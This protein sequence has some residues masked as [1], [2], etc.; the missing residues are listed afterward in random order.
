MSERL[1]REYIG[2]VTK[3]DKHL[4]AEAKKFNAGDV[5]EGIMAAA[6]ATKLMKRPT[7]MKE[8]Y[9]A[10]TVDDVQK[11]LKMIRKNVSKGPGVKSVSRSW[12][13]PGIPGGPS[14]DQIDNITL[15]IALAPSHMAA[16]LDP[17]SWDDKLE[18]Y[19]VAAVKYL[20]STQITKFA[21][22]LAKRGYADESGTPRIEGDDIILSAIGP[23]DQSGTKADFK[24]NINGQEVLP[25]SL[26]TTSP[27]MGQASGFEVDVI[28][29]Y[30]APIGLDL[31]GA[32]AGF[33]T[34]MKAIPHEWRHTKIA[35]DRDDP[36]LEKH[37]QTMKTAAKIL[38]DKTEEQLKKIVG[39]AGQNP[40]AIK[41]MLAGMGELVQKAATSGDDNVEVTKLTPTGGGTYGR[42]RFGDEFLQQLA[43]VGTLSVRRSGPHTVTVVGPA[44]DLFQ[45]RYRFEKASN[46]KK[47]PDKRFGLY[48]RTYLQTRPE[49]LE[50]AKIASESTLAL[51][52]LIYE[53]LLKEEL[54]T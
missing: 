36:T 35:T 26:K 38:A 49:I 28:Q 15:E 23:L 25:T 52:N 17:T 29:Q 6:W 31:S 14:A 5:A 13:A 19:F 21:H 10:I 53:I 46:S 2:A 43:E 11:F 44:G 7:N 40:A 50:L 48:M 47:G 4:L 9:P 33:D 39:Q 1:L 27:Q 8:K 16:L 45:V 18:K 54:K 32:K 37:F 30:F 20:N 41:K 12:S 24:I 51:R 3:S 22:R 42:Y 34:A